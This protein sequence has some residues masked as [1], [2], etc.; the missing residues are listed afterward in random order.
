MQNQLT[1]LPSSRSIRHRILADKE[2]NTFL[3]PTITMGEFLNRLLRVPNAIN[4]DS[5]RRNLLLLEASE[6]KNFASLEIERNFF[7]FTQNSS[8]IFRFLEELSGEEVDINTLELSDTY[9]DYEEHLHV[10]GELY[11]RYEKIC[12]REKVIDPIFLKKDYEL[13]LDYLKRFEKLRLVLEGYLSNFEMSVLLA[14]SQAVNVELEFFATPYNDKMTQ[15]LNDLGFE[16]HEGHYYHLEIRDRKSLHVRPLQEQKK[17]TCKQF[18]ERLEQIAFIK[19]QVYLMVDSGMDPE[20][21]A[22]IVPDENFASQIRLFDS[23]SNFNFAMGR[24]FTQSDFYKKLHAS[25][26]GLDTLSIQNSVRINRLGS[27]SFELLRPFYHERYTK[28]NFDLLIDHILEDEDKNIRELIV[29]ECY[30]FENLHE[31]LIG[32]SMK[33]VLHI[34]IER[35]RTLTLDDVGGGK[36][37][38]MGLL[39]SRGVSFDG[40]VIIDFNEAYVPRSSEKDLFLN[41]AIR[42]NSGLPTQKDREALQKHYYHM[43]ISRAQAVAI[44]YVESDDAIPSRFLT[45]L[46][47]DKG[48]VVDS[49]AYASLLFKK[50]SQTTFTCKEIIAP[51]DF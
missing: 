43:L 4:L 21:I 46:G 45:Q 38:V 34:F 22:V 48:E 31:H 25:I 36:I 40:V 33:Q 12:Q 1:I 26:Q 15:K 42:Q 18:S 10:L 20:K 49:E 50:G 27:D 6:F 47:I 19:E 7:T 11:K 35:I 41:S 30:Q 16:L 37:T 5:D 39:E 2:R 9:G 23:E 44:S 24:A 17:I 29:H 32:L 8:Y 13:N 3:N 14:C 28:E 51:F